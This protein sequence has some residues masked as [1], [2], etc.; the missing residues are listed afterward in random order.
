MSYKN[1]FKKNKKIIKMNEFDDDDNIYSY[2]EKNFSD[3]NFEEVYE[4][5]S[6]NKDWENKLNLTNKNISSTSNYEKIK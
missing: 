5:N 2:I 6:K 4:K 1:E 3:Y